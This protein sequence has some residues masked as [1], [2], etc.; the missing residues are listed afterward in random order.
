MSGVKKAMQKNARK[1]EN[2]NMAE[3]R[4]RETISW[5]NVSKKNTLESIY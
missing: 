1:G 4:D 2:G 3:S 5:T